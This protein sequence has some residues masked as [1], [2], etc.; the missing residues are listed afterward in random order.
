MRKTQIQASHAKWS[1]YLIKGVQAELGHRF[2]HCFDQVQQ[3]SMPRTH[4]HPQKCPA[5]DNTRES[6]ETRHTSINAWIWFHF[7]FKENTSE[8]ESCG[9]S[10]NSTVTHMLFSL[11][12][13]CHSDKETIK[14]LTLPCS[15]SVTINLQ[16]L[17]WALKPGNR[18]Q[19]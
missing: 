18:K 17:R 13:C 3:L 5:G 1:C 9:N 6:T 12:H 2:V 19:S 15:L 4:F 7:L 8:T 11:R 16:S 10:D 14:D